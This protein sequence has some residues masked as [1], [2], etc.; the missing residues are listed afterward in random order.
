MFALT[1]LTLPKWSFPSQ[2]NSSQ[3]HFLGFML[4]GIL[5]LSTVLL[6]QFCWSTIPSLE[7]VV[8]LLSL[9]LLS[10]QLLSLKP[11]VDTEFFLGSS[12][13]SSYARLGVSGNYIWARSF[14]GAAAMLRSHVPDYI[15]RVASSICWS[16]RRSRFFRHS[17]SWICLRNCSVPFKVHVSCTS[18]MPWIRWF[19]W[20][21]SVILNFVPFSISLVRTVRW[22]CSTIIA[23]PSWNPQ[24]GTSGRQVAPGFL[25]FFD[26]GL[27]VIN[28][29][30]SP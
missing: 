26:S 10:Y 8:K 19:S 13:S 2:A 27:T 20:L 21:M 7:L 11:W 29:H 16:L 5:E 23:V 14:I 12:T 22:S 6:A 17:S 28:D 4:P 30:E 18:P 3:T 15:Y 1:E 24:V 25:F 9:R